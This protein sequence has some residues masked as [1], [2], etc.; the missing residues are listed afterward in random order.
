MVSSE[1]AGSN[2]VVPVSN[3]PEPKQ[4]PF[5]SLPI[6]IHFMI[7]RYLGIRSLS[8]LMCTCRSFRDIHFE[9]LH[10]RY[11]NRKAL[12]FADR[13]MRPMR[14]DFR[15][16]HGGH[17]I[18]IAAQRGNEVLVGRLI[19]GG[20]KVDTMCKRCS[21]PLHLALRFGHLRLAITL[22]N[23]WNAAT[24]IR[25][26][27]KGAHRSPSVNNTPPVLPLEVLLHLATGRWSWWPGP[28]PPPPTGADLDATIPLMRILLD[29]TAEK[30]VA[31]I[32]GH[33]LISYIAKR[34]MC[35]LSTEIKKG[36]I[37]LLLEFGA[38]INDDL[39][40]HASLAGKW[41][42][43]VPYE[44]AL[45]SATRSGDTAVVV[46][47]LLAGAEINRRDSSGTTALHAAA[48]AREHGKGCGFVTCMK[49]SKKLLYI[50][51]GAGADV[52]ARDNRGLD[53]LAL[54]TCNEATELAELLQGKMLG[55]APVQFYAGHKI[56]SGK[57]IIECE[58]VERISECPPET[59]RW[60]RSGRRGSV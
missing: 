57:P 58:K 55:Q 48:H 10:H 9:L 47:L 15:C 28:A 30:D 34:P 26:Y 51:L 24:N 33:R 12:Y 6:E 21:T 4:T 1:T 36:L 44:S 25:C 3:G 27:M 8:R 11:A 59:V 32:S 20:I 60:A 23:V 40:Q 37:A 5:I 43:G 53:A 39:A 41:W 45:V 56:P 14:P 46:Q 49:S 50:L 7:G 19:R 42:L 16:S 18:L 38:S 54:A 52:W 2:G 31:S 29:R 35:Q 17:G 13:T 22:L